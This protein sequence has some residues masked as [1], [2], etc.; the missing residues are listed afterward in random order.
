MAVKYNNISIRFYDNQPDIIQQFKTMLKNV[1]T[2]YIPDRPNKEILKHSKPTDFTKLFL[3]KY[4]NNNFAK[5]LSYFRNNE[6]SINMGF[7]LN[8]AED[9]LNDMGIHPVRDPKNGIHVSTGS[10]GCGILVAVGLALADKSKNIYLGF[11]ICC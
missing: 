8:N 4:P 3:K 7:S 10:L 6:K 9:L 5:Y 1:D 11:V 2:I